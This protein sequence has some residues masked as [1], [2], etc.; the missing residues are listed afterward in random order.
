MAAV[1][2]ISD[3]GVWT[4]SQTVSDIFCCFRHRT[5]EKTAS[6]TD[7]NNMTTNFLNR[8]GDLVDGGNESRLSALDTVSLHSTVSN[9]SGVEGGIKWSKESDAKEPVVHNRVRQLNSAD[10]HQSLKS[11]LVTTDELQQQ[12]SVMHHADEF[13]DSALDSSV[14]SQQCKEWIG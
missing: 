1:R 5:T 8:Q 6:Y 9:T 13:A 4:A 7:G 2:A 14:H 11:L 12:P 3:A 10:M